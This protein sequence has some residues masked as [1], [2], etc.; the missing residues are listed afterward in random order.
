MAKI[1]PI[2]KGIKSHLIF[3]QTFTIY[4]TTAYIKTQFT[5]PEPK[6]EYVHL[7]VSFLFFPENY[8]V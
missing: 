6:I 7:Y 3:N 8:V 2:L 5:G 1:Y 4:L